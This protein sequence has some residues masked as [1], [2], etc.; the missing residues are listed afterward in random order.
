MSSGVR[1]AEAHVNKVLYFDVHKHGESLEPVAVDR[2]NALHHLERLA[3]EY[4]LVQHQPPD[5]PQAKAQDRPWRRRRPT[6]GAADSHW[7][8]RRPA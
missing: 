5:A 2:H 6:R 4:A 7:R 3:Q 1:R 8:R